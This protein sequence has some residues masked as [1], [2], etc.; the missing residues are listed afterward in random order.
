MECEVRV[1]AREKAAAGG[2]SRAP[3]QAANR[4]VVFDRHVQV[5]TRYQHAAVTG[6][7]A[8]LGQDRPPVKVKQTGVR[9]MN[10]Q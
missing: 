8:H 2:R 9:T 1:N 4:P 6:R 3:E 5:D 7:V 10:E